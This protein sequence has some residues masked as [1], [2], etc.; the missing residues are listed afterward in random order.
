M[1]ILIIEDELKLGQSIK[2]GL[3][4]EGYAVEHVTNAEDGLNYAQNDDYDLI[5]LDRMLP[6]GQ[7]G[8]ELC[9]QLRSDS[10]NGPILVLT[11]MTQTSD[12]VIGLRSGADD[13]LAKPFAFD[14]LVARVQALM[15]RPSKIV[16]PKIST[17]NIELDLSTKQVLL[18]GRIIS[19]TKKEYSLLEYLAHNK[20]VIV[21][22]DQ[23]VD[24]VWDF[25]SDILPNTVEVFIRSLRKKLGKSSIETVRGFGYRMAV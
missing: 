19:L 7:D 21:S 25:E 20:N 1:K 2:R 8:L 11:A 24:H 18:K 6:N 3:E 10:W 14:E 23:I 17:G 12:K 13:Y 4:Q 15:R 9:K 5:V 16:G 22:K